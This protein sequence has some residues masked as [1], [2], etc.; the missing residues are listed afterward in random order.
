MMALYTTTTSDDPL[1]P[2]NASRLA[3]TAWLRHPH[4]FAMEHIPKS[5]ADALSSRRR[6]NKSEILLHSSLKSGAV[7]HMDTA[8]VLQQGTGSHYPSTSH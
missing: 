4:P 6:I 3:P 5:T 8:L 1:G 2:H 7:T